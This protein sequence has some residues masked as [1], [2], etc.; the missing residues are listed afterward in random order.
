MANLGAAVRG[1]DGMFL[2]GNFSDEAKAKGKAAKCGGV[3]VRYRPK[4]K[5]TFRFLVKSDTLDGRG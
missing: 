4:G 3:V 1:R 2:R 5:Q